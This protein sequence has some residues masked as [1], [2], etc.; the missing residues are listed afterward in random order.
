MNTFLKDISKFIAQNFLSFWIRFRCFN[1]SFDPFLGICWSCETKLSPN[2]L[3]CPSCG[4]E[5]D[6]IVMDP[7]SGQMVQKRPEE[8]STQILPDRT[9]LSLSPDLNE[10]FAF[11]SVNCQSETVKP[12]IRT[13]GTTNWIADPVKLTSDPTFSAQMTSAESVYENPRPKLPEAE[14]GFSNP[15]PQLP[16]AGSHNNKN[17][18]ESIRNEVSITNGRPMLPTAESHVP[19]IGPMSQQREPSYPNHQLQM[20]E[21]FYRKMEPSYQNN[22]PPSQASKRTEPSNQNFRPTFPMPGSYY[23]HEKLVSPGT[24]R[25]YFSAQ[26][27]PG[28]MDRNQDINSNAGFRVQGQKFPSAETNH[29]N[30]RPGLSIADLTYGNQ[31]P[32]Y[33]RPETLFQTPSSQL[34]RP[35]SSFPRPDM[36]YQSPGSS[37]ERHEF[38]FRDHN[39]SFSTPN[40][41][42]S[43]PKQPSGNQDV[44]QYAIPSFYQDQRI[45]ETS[46]ASEK[47]ADYW[48]CKH[49][50]FHNPLNTKV[51][52]MCWK[53][54][55]VSTEKPDP[56]FEVSFFRRS[57]ICKIN[58][59]NL[60]E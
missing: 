12:M 43:I 6:D 46:K 36:S 32:V 59:D 45:V 24:E 8:H 53:T 16:K 9:D 54:S 50:T 18:P 47:S 30:S 21:S 10:E 28:M 48:S 33:P 41:V 57:K 56:N 29:G 38:S 23:P 22:R 44:S 13:G 42:M 55:F 14:S 60:C 40:N 15:R 7:E 20:A 26:S 5:R 25:S 3:E 1:N 39:P 58:R 49:C 52:Q 17:N 51:C 4:T 34:Q 37:L 31:K 27:L 19:N 2:K 35:Q 11:S